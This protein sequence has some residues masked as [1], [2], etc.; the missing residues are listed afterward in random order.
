[1]EGFRTSQIPA[2][3]EPLANRLEALKRY[4]N[5]GVRVAR[6]K[7]ATLWALP[8]PNVQIEIAQKIKLLQ[9]TIDL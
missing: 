9:S 6:P 5:C 1:M 8:S 4:Q 2:D 3:E 7:P